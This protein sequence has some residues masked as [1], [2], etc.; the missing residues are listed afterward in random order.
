MYFKALVLI[1]L[2]SAVFWVGGLYYV[3]F[4]LLQEVRTAED[5][6][7]HRPI[8]KRTGR[9]FRLYSAVAAFLLLVS[10][11]LLL[12]QRTYRSGLRF[13]ALLTMILGWAFLTAMV[14]GSMPQ[15][16]FSGRPDDI[17]E[18][19]REQWHPNRLFWIHLAASLIGTVALA[20]GTVLA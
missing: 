17:E 10:G 13:G 8:L 18:K 11:L 5:P 14:Y 2:L 9:R 20:A 7:Q 1:H 16:A 15:E 6:H 19:E 3:T 4:V 12:P